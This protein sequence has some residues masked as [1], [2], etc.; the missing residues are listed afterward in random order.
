[1]GQQ[2]SFDGFVHPNKEYIIDGVKHDPIPNLQYPSRKIADKLAKD[3][4]NMYVDIRTILD[5]NDIPHWVYFGTLLG[6]VRHKGFIPW[7][8]DWDIKIRFG[9]I[10]KLKSA[11][12]DNKQYKLKYLDRDS[13]FIKVFPID[14][15]NMGVPFID[16]FFDIEKDDKQGSCEFQNCLE[17]C[18]NINIDKTDIFPLN[19]AIFEDIWVYIPN[20]PDKLLT[21]KY[22]NYHQIFVDKPHSD[23]TWMEIGKDVQPY[24]ST[25]HFTFY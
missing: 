24:I 11:F 12:E 21:L 16:I 18:T 8:D 23:Y 9:D 6:A 13:C 2:Q 5:N 14:A 19:K 15:I 4:K 20:K 25:E 10:N 7:D 22:G 1:M 17:T 3:L